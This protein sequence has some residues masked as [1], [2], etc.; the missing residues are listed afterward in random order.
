MGHVTVKENVFS[1]C[2]HTRYWSQYLHSSIV[3]KVEIKKQIMQNCVN[4]M[5]V[6]LFNTPVKHGHPSWRQ[7]GSHITFSILNAAVI[8]RNF[9]PILLFF[10]FLLLFQ[11][12]IVSEIMGAEP[13]GA[14][15]A[16][17]LPIPTKSRIRNDYSCCL[18]TSFFEARICLS[19]RLSFLKLEQNL[20]IT[21]SLLN[22]CF[23]VTHPLVYFML[24]DKIE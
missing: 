15:N 6:A 9:A 24:I 10:P 14:Q 22:F 16:E 18:H 13:Y 7:Q 8:A 23:K 2:N 4:D 12:C 17:S 21:F 20:S 5:A 19:I 3:H 1:L 11:C